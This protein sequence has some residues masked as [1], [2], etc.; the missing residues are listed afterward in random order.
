MFFNIILLC[1]I[2]VVVLLL[3]KQSYIEGFFDIPVPAHVALTE[4]S[5][6]KFGQL[7]NMF[8]LTDP[9]IDINPV[10]ANNIRQALNGLSTTPGPDGHT[11]AQP[12]DI[13]IP[14]QL[15]DGM[16]QA[17]YCQKAPNTCGAFDDPL[18]VQNNCGMSFDITG[19]DS[20]GKPHVGGLYISPDNR[21]QQT[22]MAANVEETGSPPYDPYKVYQPTLGTA[23]PGTFGITKDSC[24]VVKEKVDCSTKQSFNSPNCTQ[25]YTSQT[26][27]R[28]DPRTGRLP[29]TLYLFGDTRTQAALLT[30]IPGLSFDNK[31][32]PAEGLQVQFP[33]D[34]EGKTF[35]LIGDGG[36]LSGYIEGK[37]ARGTFKLDLLSLV[38][39]DTVTGS[40]PRIIGTKI[41]NGFRCVNM[42]PGKG[43]RAMALA[44]L[45]PFSFINMFDGDALTCDNGPIITQAASATFLESDPCFGKGNQPGNYKMECLQ[46]RWMQLGG[47]PD[48]TGYPDT[49]AKADALQ[50]PNGT[51]LD[52]DGIIDSLSGIMIKALTGKDTNGQILSIPEWNSASMFA[53][54]VPINTPCDGPG[55][56]APIS[57]ACAAYLYSNQ[58]TQSHVGATYTLPSSQIAHTLGQIE[59]FIDTPITYNYPGA[60]LDPTTPSGQPVYQQAG[61]VE[62]IKQTYDAAS[63][64][65]NDNTKKN[66][67][68]ADAIRQAYGVNLGSVASN[69][70]D[71]DVRVPAGQSTKTYAD[72]KQFCESKGQRL[73]ESGEI[74]D[75]KSRIVIN[76]ELTSEF[77]GDNWIAVGDNPNEWLT[78]NRNDNRYCKTHTEVANYLPEW[79]SKRDPTGW[80]RLAKCCSG[81]AYVQGRYI[82]FQYNH[83]ECLNLTQVQVYTSQDDSI[84]VITPQ[85]KVTR[86]SVGYWGGIFPEVNFVD[87]SKGPFVHTSCGDVPWVMVDLG[88]VTPIYKVLLT[89]RTDCCMERVL[90]TTMI[91]L[92]GSMKPV[93]NSDPIISV[94]TTYTY[95]PPNKGVYADLNG[96]K[97]NPGYTYAGCWRDTGDRAVPQNDSLYPTL[98]DNYKAREDAIK[99]CYEVA[100]LKGDKV[101]ALQD[102][103]WC[104]SSPNQ[105]DY[106]KYGRSDQC[107]GRGKGGGWANDVYIIGDED[108][109][110][111]VEKKNIYGNNGTTTCE[112]YCSGVDGGSW[113]NELPDDWNGAACSDV[114]PGIENCYTT[115]TFQPGVSTCVCKKTGSGWRKGGWL[116][117]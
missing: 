20:S 71:F 21:D 69:K 36:Y 75:M 51:A 117:Q 29:T 31:K 97:P 35:L 41:F 93:Y 39:S 112:R 110:A 72:M 44:C 24:I 13:M 94:N 81:G 58:G 7:T 1:I 42:S 37:T 68:R 43:K 106:K 96:D 55:G 46:S 66:G 99:K 82:R 89:N 113:N 111:P 86:S 57:Q 54:G 105:S 50:K 17:S 45:M 19:T 91:V 100:K 115:F 76:P 114:G 77:P 10:T 85:T 87:R 80:E 49:Q 32:I 56:Q 14:D 6:K 12:N 33:E 25:C 108:I 92:N 2:S 5:S 102:D 109:N 38:Q 65:A 27:N 26:F 3:Y 101:F 116:N 4:D 95:F 70:N 47:T 53:T 103:G 8:N 11:L 64:L 16:R 67:E 88:A 52:I 59:G 78:L 61:S 98:M 60:G 84:G 15:P 79:G 62:Q 48:G 22:Q 73:C 74:C 107:Y 18:F 104:A 23:K 83:V 40:K 30:Q 9:S 63:R 34:S 90:G 28:V